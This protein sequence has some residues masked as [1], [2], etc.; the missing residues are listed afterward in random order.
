MSILGVARGFVIALSIVVAT[1]L[2][3]LWVHS[4]LNLAMVTFPANQDGACGIIWSCG[5]V[6]FGWNPGPSHGGEHSYDRV[7]GRL[8][9][10]VSPGASNII[11]PGPANVWGPLL[12]MYS[13]P[14]P[15]PPHWEFAGIVFENGPTI[16]LFL[17]IWLL[18]A[19]ALAPGLFVAWR[20]WARRWRR[21]R[22]HCAKCGYDLRASSDR[23]PECGTQIP[24]G[25]GQRTKAVT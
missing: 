5:E 17:P 21:R 10:S 18:T 6:G 11:L 16:M 4:D 2:A 13:N 3:A 1:G 19:G 9:Y 23:C 8:G 7:S 22:G 12:R 24:S 14:P 20:I 25:G 15:D